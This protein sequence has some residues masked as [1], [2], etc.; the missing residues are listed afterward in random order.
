IALASG[1]SAPEQLTLVTVPST[2]PQ[3]SG[4]LTVMLT[5]TGST[6]YGVLWPIRIAAVWVPGWSCSTAELSSVT[7]TVMLSPGASVKLVVSRLSHGTSVAGASQLLHS[8]CTSEPGLGLNP[9]V[10][11]PTL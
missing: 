3:V 2:L 11:P 1:A 6:G 9:P 5:A 7:V 4:A 10:D 8:G